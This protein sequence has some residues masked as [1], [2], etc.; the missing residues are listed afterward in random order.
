MMMGRNFIILIVALFVS[1]S[2]LAQQSN[3]VRVFDYTSKTPKGLLTDRSVVFVNIDEENESRTN[4]K[5]IATKTQPA[6]ASMGIDV[7]G[8]FNVQDV[9]AGLETQRAFAKFLL[10]RNI[11]NILIIEKTSRQYTMKMVHF[12]EKQNFLDQ[13]QKAWK[14]QGS[15]LDD[16]LSN[17]RRA[18]GAS[19]MTQENF[20]VTKTPEFFED[21]NLFKRG[22]YDDYN[23]DLKLDKLAIPIFSQ[24]SI[25]SNISESTIQ[26]SN[27]NATL[28]QDSLDL[29]S[30]MK[31]YPFQY[32]F[33]NP[34]KTEKKLR[35]DKYEFVLYYLNTSERV[36][37]ELLNYS[38]EKRSISNQPVIKFYVKHIFSGEIYLGKWDASTS[39][40][41]AL[42]NHL[43]GIKARVEKNN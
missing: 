10:D 36:I 19:G 29:V 32:G 37:Q 16:I 40:Q 31:T 24:I 41:Q 38:E 25:P 2:S 34:D 11:N 35:N 12:N 30:I 21:I 4:W 22:R 43:E 18:V 42:R 15:G 6:F 1:Y 23:R 27:R 33:V 39:W 14:T 17:L 9:F 3:F 20:L 7:I 28:R 26:I 13:G 5:K 8:Y